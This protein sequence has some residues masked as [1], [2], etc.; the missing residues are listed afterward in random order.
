ADECGFFC[1]AQAFF[2]D[3]FGSRENI[4]AQASCSGF[5]QCF[6][7]RG[8]VAGGAGETEIVVNYLVKDYR[9]VSGDQLHKQLQGLSSPA[10]YYKSGNQ[11]V[12]VTGDRISY[13]TENN[14]GSLTVSQNVQLQ[15]KSVNIV[16]A[17]SG[18]GSPITY[19]I[20][21]NAVVRRTEE[22]SG[23]TL[24]FN[25]NGD[26]TKIK[27]NDGSIDV[28]T[29][30]DEHLEYIRDYSGQVNVVNNADQLVKKITYKQARV[31]HIVSYDTPGNNAKR[32]EIYYDDASGE[33]VKKL[34]IDGSQTIERLTENGKITVNTLAGT[35][36]LGKKVTEG[37]TT[38]TIAYDFNSQKPTKEVALDSF[39][40]RERTIDYKN[41]IPNIEKIT[42]PN[43]LPVTIHYDSQGRKEEVVT[44]DNIV[45]GITTQKYNPA[46][47]KRVSEKVSDISGT[48]EKL[49][50][51]NGETVTKEIITQGDTATEVTKGPGGIDQEIVII[52]NGKI[53]KM[54]TLN[55]QTA[56]ITERTYNQDATLASTTVQKNNELVVTTTPTSSGE[57]II[58]KNDQGKILQKYTRDGADSILETYDGS[59]KV[60]KKETLVGAT[61]TTEEFNNN[62][63]L[64]KVVDSG[65]TKETYSYENGKETEYRKEGSGENILRSKIGE[66]THTSTFKNDGTSVREVKDKSNK[67]LS[68]DY[69]DK[70][71]NLV[72]PQAGT[73]NWAVQAVKVGKS[74]ESDGKI[75]VLTQKTDGTFQFQEYGSTTSADISDVEKIKAVPSYEVGEIISDHVY[76]GTYKG[77]PVFSTLVPNPT[78]SYDAKGQQSVTD[79]TLGSSA[80]TSPIV[81]QLSNPTLIPISSSAPTSGVASRETVSES[82]KTYIIH[83]LDNG[84]VLVTC[85][86]CSSGDL[87]PAAVTDK[88]EALEGAS[89]ERI[90]AA[91]TAITTEK[92]PNTVTGITNPELSQAYAELAEE[93]VNGPPQVTVKYSDELRI[94]KDTIKTPLDYD[95]TLLS[96]SCANGYDCDD[97]RNFI[98]ALDIYNPSIFS[99]DG[100][101]MVDTPFRVPLGP[102]L[103]Q[104]PESI[105]TTE[106][107]T[108]ASVEGREHIFVGTDGFFYD[109]VGGKVSNA[110]HADLKREINVGN[111]KPF[112]DALLKAKSLPPPTDST[113]AS[114]NYFLAA[115]YLEETN[116]AKAVEYYTHAI[117]LAD[118]P[119]DAA[120]YASYAAAI[121]PTDADKIFFAELAA[122]NYIA[123]GKEE[124]ANG[125]EKAASGYKEAA[126]D[127][128]ARA[129][130]AVPEAEGATLRTKLVELSKSPPPQAIAGLGT[131]P[132]TSQLEEQLQAG[133]MKILSAEGATTYVVED[134]IW[135]ENGERKD[136]RAYEQQ[137]DGK[138]KEVQ[139]TDKAKIN[140][141]TKA[142]FQGRVPKEIYDLVKDS[143]TIDWVTKDNINLG[144]ESN[145]VMKHNDNG[146]T[147]IEVSGPSVQV[148]GSI[149]LASS[150][151]R[152]RVALGTA[153]VFS[154]S[155][156]QIA[157]GEVSVPVVGDEPDETYFIKQ[158]DINSLLNNKKVTLYEDEAKTKEIASLEGEGIKRDTEDNI[159]AGTLVYKE[160]SFIDTTT[161]K[162]LNSDGQVAQ[163]EV[164]GLTGTVIYDGDENP[165]ALKNDEGNGVT[166]LQ[167]L[168][169]NRVIGREIQVEGHTLSVLY[170]EDGSTQY[171]YNGRT[172][173]CSNGDYSCAAA[174][175]NKPEVTLT[176]VRQAFEARSEAEKKVAEAREAVAAASAGSDEEKA[177][178]AATLTQAEAALIAAQKEAGEFE[179][180]GVDDKAKSAAILNSIDREKTS[181]AE[182]FGAIQGAL[183]SVRTYPALSNLIFGEDFGLIVKPSELDRIF[184]PLL[185]EQFFASAICEAEFDIQPEGMA[186]IKTPT[187]QYQAVAKIEAERTKEKQPVFCTK[188]A[189][190]EEFYCN[191]GQVCS[192]GLCYLDANNDQFPDDRTPA[193][194]YLYKISW[195]VSAPQD[196]SQTP[197]IDET[198]GVAVSFNVFLDKNTA[199]GINYNEQ[200]NLPLYRFAGNIQSPIELRNGDRDG[201]YIIKYSEAIYNE[202][203]IKWKSPPSTVQFNDQGPNSYDAIA[204]FTN[205]KDVCM[206]VEVTERGTV[207]WE[208]LD[209]DY[210]EESQ[211]QEQQ[212]RTTSNV[213][214]TEW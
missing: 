179:K 120:D 201:D 29:F 175:A 93:A 178:A 207:T 146:F 21:S 156:E 49:L 211:Q 57:I 188:K 150:I 95:N 182:I 85:N 4:A 131:N 34:E 161:R 60:I 94:K 118:T 63:L 24:D 126:T 145:I 185:G 73:E 135:G 101:I 75:G 50:A 6:W 171:N 114:R 191:E 84:R 133:T 42:E 35:K 176:Q 45:T 62:V 17:T 198:T 33:E 104:V 52:K 69:Y 11:W 130:T 13:F 189:D 80:L 26:L 205:V 82:G 106:G 72:I 197:L 117:E 119:E 157:A 203:C 142:E 180:G 186:I 143:K 19:H 103:N 113:Q 20:Q 55:L 58:T 116:P 74:V 37:T 206:D 22:G 14:Q 140:A 173:T 168:K 115:S 209:E 147:L 128:L 70:D 108:A 200:D 77:K 195:A 194:G 65:D 129:I 138:W 38:T 167:D 151:N 27:T 31:S 54:T 53:T 177:A 112:T 100:Y 88:I 44:G 28:G 132:T 163:I 46:T 48:T 3:F 109:R 68:Y 170:L 102:G 212:S 79:S 90:T 127:V 158:E 91:K 86:G 144:P 9:E 30:S 153:T 41:G 160:E 124:A 5:W 125:N 139:T 196:V 36:I 2:S 141:I 61:K 67:V 137:A 59:E 172:E 18:S 89:S 10:K 107:I 76:L 204:G 97:A 56:E 32:T 148:P 155:K 208:Y 15:A 190:T 81:K 7:G 123:A 213:E 181:F 12:Q 23:Y 105:I 136:F 8:N 134:N 122:D 51:A 25:A 78:F 66:N 152:R 159:I 166:L 39:N 192:E 121:A 43:K 111:A 214:R 187:G 40:S 165:L 202:A 183:G 174:V 1:K 210:E 149:N 193:L 162:S 87:A 184:A 169:N 154:Q 164:E 99:R 71:N 98:E 96:L 16:E 199:E 110:I 47:G 64:K 83:T 92:N